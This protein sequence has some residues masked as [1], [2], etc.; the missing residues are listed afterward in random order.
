MGRNIYKLFVEY[1]GRNFYGSQI[2]SSLRTVEGV[3]KDTISKLIDGN[4]KLFFS[5]RTDAGVHALCN[6]VKL[7]CSKEINNKKEFLNKL[8][9]FLPDDLKVKKIQKVK[10]DFDPRNV[11]YK[12]YQYTI[13]NSFYP[14]TLFKE[15]VWWVKE[16][17]SLK[18]L[19]EAA[20]VI[21]STKD[22][23]FATTKD[24]IKTKRDTFCVI[25]VNVVKSGDFIRIIFKGKRFLHRLIRNLVSLMVEVAKGNLEIK[26]F[27]KIIS[28]WKYFKGKSAP[29]CG[30][31]LMKIVQ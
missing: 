30:L 19:K 4:F 23:S 31:I 9:F 6:V 2:Q 26:D 17:L 11:K 1:N 8:N 18:L 14:P 3:L 12:I 27:K 16:K 7:V 21:C 22:F 25:E 15:Y 28:S 13:Y 10:K 29:A 5:S 24:F 20:R